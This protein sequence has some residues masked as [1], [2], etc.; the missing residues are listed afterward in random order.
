MLTQTD[1]GRERSVA[2]LQALLRAGRAR[3]PV[4]SSAPGPA[5]GSGRVGQR[6]AGEAGAQVGDGQIASSRC[7]PRRVAEPTWGRTSRFGAPQQRVVGG[8]GSGSVTSRPAPARRPERSAS[9][10]R[11]LVDERRRA[12]C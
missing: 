5:P 1:G 4:L 7:A 2:E 6:L 10:Q 12:R 11:G 9:A 8:S 3:R